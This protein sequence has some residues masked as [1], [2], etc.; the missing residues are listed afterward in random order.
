MGSEQVGSE[1]HVVF[2]S[3]FAKARAIDWTWTD[4]HFEPKG[5]ESLDDSL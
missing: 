1:R 2:E 4:C 5:P 3:D